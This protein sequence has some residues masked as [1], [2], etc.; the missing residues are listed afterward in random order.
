MK[1]TEEQ[2]KMVAEATKAQLE[3]R[4]SLV[5]AVSEVLTPEQR[6][7]AGLDSRRKKKAN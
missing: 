3:A 5:T 1:L 2:Q 6:E 4:Q 7:K